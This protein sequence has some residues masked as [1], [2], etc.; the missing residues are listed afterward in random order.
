MRRTMCS[1]AEEERVGLVGMGVE[2]FGAFCGLAGA[3]D[4]GLGFGWIGVGGLEWVGLG[5]VAG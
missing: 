1:R 2:G 5:T 4:E 3:E